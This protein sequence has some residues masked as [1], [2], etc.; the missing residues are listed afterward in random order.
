L[1]WKGTLISEATGFCNCL[2][3]SSS[4]AAWRETWEIAVRSMAKMAR[5]NPIREEWMTEAEP[6]EL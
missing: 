5:Q 3:S 4:E 6:S 2:A 1:F